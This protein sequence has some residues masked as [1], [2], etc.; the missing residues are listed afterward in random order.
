MSESDFHPS[1]RI[2]GR[3]EIHLGSVKEDHADH[4]G[5][6]QPVDPEFCIRPLMIRIEPATTTAALAAFQPASQPRSVATEVKMDWEPLH[7]VEVAGRE[8]E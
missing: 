2:S 7:V 8:G 3:R 5:K 1:N 6:F 4:L